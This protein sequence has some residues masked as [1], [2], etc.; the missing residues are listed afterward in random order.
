MQRHP[1]L[2]IA[3]RWLKEHPNLFAWQEGNGTITLFDRATGKGRV[4]ASDEIDR[5]EERTNRIRG[6]E[7]YVIFRL[8]S[9]AQ[10]VLCDQG[11]AFAPSF[12]NTGPLELPAPVFCLR[13]YET[14]MEQLRHLP[15]ERKK[16]ALDLIMALIAIVDGAA[17]VG[18]DVERETRN[19]DAVLQRVERGEAPDPTHGA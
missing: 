17:A 4:I 14:M 7:R 15:P 10:L 12:E 9:G 16:D 18:L 5:I 13:D 3:A 1:D 19:V 8:A 11:F 6:A 2:D